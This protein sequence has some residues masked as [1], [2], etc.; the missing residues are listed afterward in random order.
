METKGS[1]GSY[2]G[3]KSVSHIANLRASSHPSVLFL[4]CLSLPQV[5]SI[6]PPLM[7]ALR[8]H[9]ECMLL[10]LFFKKPGSKSLCPDYIQ[11]IGPCFRWHPWCGDEQIEDER[12]GWGGGRGKLAWPGAQCL[13]NW[14][15]ARECGVPRWLCARWLF[16]FE[17]RLVSH[18][19]ASLVQA[20]SAKWCLSMMWRKEY[21]QSLAESSAG[22]TDPQEVHAQENEC[23]EWCFR[24]QSNSGCQRVLQFTQ[25]KME[26]SRVD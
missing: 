21:T 20:P 10:D 24:A 11:L 22:E 19:S 23:F 2:Y 15:E 18:F 3:L 6:L 4:L 26:I 9:F 25:I 17:R 7:V 12:V 13:H 8:N 14:G 1:T 5:A 16:L